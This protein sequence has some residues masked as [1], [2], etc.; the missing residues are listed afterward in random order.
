MFRNGSFVRQ[1]V[2][3][4]QFESLSYK[5]SPRRWPGE[6]YFTSLENRLPL[7]SSITRLKSFPRFHDVRSKRFTAF[8]ISVIY[9]GSTDSVEKAP[10]CGPMAVFVRNCEA[11]HFDSQ[12]LDPSKISAILEA[13]L[14]T[15][16][17][18][19]VLPALRN[20]GPSLS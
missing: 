19:L 14:Q 11:H 18:I 4:V 20:I 8:A 2:S 9:L 15:A 1:A 16:T 7:I 5:R 6:W 12:I 13:G 17:V 10:I 3:T